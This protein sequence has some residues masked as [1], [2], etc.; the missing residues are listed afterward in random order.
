VVAKTNSLEALETFRADPHGFDLVITDMTMPSLRGEELAR[1]II[2]LRPGMPIILC[3]GYSELINETQAREMGIREFVMKP[4]MV[5][6]FAETI[7]KS[8][9]TR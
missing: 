8:L 5:A 4:Y 1:E 3:T 7:R 2:A 6:N 9:N